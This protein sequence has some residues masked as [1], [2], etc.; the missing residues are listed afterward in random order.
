MFGFALF[1][2]GSVLCTLAPTI[3]VL[4]AARVLQALGGAGPVILARAIVRDLYSGAQAGRELSRMAAIM[5][6]TPAVAPVFGAALQQAF[7][8][9]SNF[10]AVAIVA[11]AFGSFVASVLPETLRERRPE[12]VSPAAIFRSFGVL[13]AN[14]PFRVYAAINALAFSGLFAFISVGSFILQGIY[15]LSEFGFAIAF[16]AGCVAFVAG[17]VR[18]LARRASLRPG[19]V[20]R[21]RRDAACRRRAEA[22]LSA[23]GARRRS[24]WR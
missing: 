20:H 2:V 13:L 17:S 4:L 12:L 14:A 16:G 24:R 5:G 22:S 1:A 15:G 19:A 21:H 7:G 9:R 11:V 8:W 23:C 3:E 18:L 6:F 10:A